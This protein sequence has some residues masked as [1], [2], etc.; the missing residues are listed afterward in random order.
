[1]IV[2]WRLYGIMIMVI[3]LWYLEP[4]LINWSCLYRPGSVYGWRAA[5]P[6]LILWSLSIY[7][8]G[9]RRCSCLIETSAHT[10]GHFYICT[11][12]QTIFIELISWSI[13]S[14]TQVT[15]VL[16]IVCCNCCGFKY[17]P[18]SR[19]LIVVRSL[20]TLNWILPRCTCKYCI[21]VYC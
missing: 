4:L 17:C 2:I 20:I 8:C 5:R 3:Y 19:V 1:M 7:R 6:E 18:L 14:W 13:P 9:R 16:Q 21:V 12:F 10:F 15:P 11:H